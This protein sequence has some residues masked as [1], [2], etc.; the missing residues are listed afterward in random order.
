[1]NGQPRR[2][3]YLLF[4]NVTIG[5]IS[6]ILGIPGGHKDKNNFS[7]FLLS[8]YPFSTLPL[9]LHPITGIGLLAISYIPYIENIISTARDKPRIYE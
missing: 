7:L 4:Q 6:F 1:V 9:T 8:G 3:K 2:K 5:I